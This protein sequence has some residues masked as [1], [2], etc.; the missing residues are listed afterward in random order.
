MKLV[1]DGYT[2]QYAEAE[3]LDLL[4]EEFKFVLCQEK[5]YKTQILED[6]IE[7]LEYSF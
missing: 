4:D 6:V 7:V 1:S 3:C 2:Y 5:S